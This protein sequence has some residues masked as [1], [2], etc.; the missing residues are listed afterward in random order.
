VAYACEHAMP[1]TAA[2]GWRRAGQRGRGRL[3]EDLRVFPL[4]PYEIFREGRYVK[5]PLVWAWIFTSSRMIWLVAQP[6]HALWLPGEQAGAGR[7]ASSWKG[8]LGS[9]CYFI[10]QQPSC[11]YTSS[12]SFR[13]YIIQ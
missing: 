11:S 13:F 5:N 8:W 12:F 3:I 6:R 4:R 1:A 7:E 2:G 10:R 9:K